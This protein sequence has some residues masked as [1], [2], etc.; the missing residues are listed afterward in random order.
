[1]LRVVRITRSVTYQIHRREDVQ[2]VPRQV[3]R[4]VAVLVSRQ[5]PH[6]V[7]YTMA[8]RGRGYRTRYGAQTTGTDASQELDNL[9]KSYYPIVNNK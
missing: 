5:A 3:A 2:Q 7:K 9:L 4:Q 1:V 8:L 6:P